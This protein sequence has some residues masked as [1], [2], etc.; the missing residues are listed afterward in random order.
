[1]LRASVD[2]LIDFSEFDPLDRFWYIKLNLL[3]DQ[4]ERRYCMKYA[5]FS[6][7]RHTLLATSGMLDETSAKYHFEQQQDLHRSWLNMLLDRNPESEE[8]RQRRIMSEWQHSWESQ[9]GDLDDPDTQEN[10]DAVADW[11]KQ[12]RTE[13]S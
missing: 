2:G 10:I 11:L 8:S 3:L 9:F 7:M 13:A 12:Q 6:I 5:E 1:M 4:V